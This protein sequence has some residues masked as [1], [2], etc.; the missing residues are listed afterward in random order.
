MANDTDVLIIGAGQCGLALSNRLRARHIEHRAVEAN[1][2]PGD[3]WRRRWD[4]LRLFTPS[5]Y[6]GLP[7]LPFPGSSR[8]RPSAGEFADYL[9][10]YAEHIGFPAAYGETVTSASPD[11]AGGF[12]VHTAASSGP[13]VRRS[14]R[15]VVATGG[16]TAPTV[17]SE[18]AALD[19]GIAQ[20]HTD[21]YHRPDDLPGDR[22]L[23]VG[24][25][26]SGVQLAVELAHAG[27]TVTVAGRPTP[28]IPAP[29]L[30]IAGGLWFAFLH[31]V[32]TRGTPMGRKAAP[33]AIG[34]GAPLIGIS[35]NDLDR[36]GVRR[37]SRFDG[38]VDG[39]PRLADGSLIE[40]DAVLWAT[41]YHP[42]APLIAGLSVDDHG[43][44]D[45]DRGMSSA[46]PGLAFLG[47]PFQFGLTSTL[48]GGTDR[49]ATY[50]ADRLA[51][52][53]SGPDGP[54]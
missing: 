24:C 9:D 11:P 29:V 23:V 12:T 35:T 14:R 49:D 4:S 37:V 43:I 22:V 40:V 48:I 2:A 52:D 3:V 6:D 19:R 27:R 45:H 26:A 54:S 38:A 25:G 46:C 21:D 16:H 10:A 15:L 18:A 42:A 33:K 36:Q 5:R 28:S 31:R 41:G 30:A 51:A 32:L 1:S 47:L 20:L 44:P 53:V 39:V 34:S 7:G 50:L 8:Y 17:P 13:R